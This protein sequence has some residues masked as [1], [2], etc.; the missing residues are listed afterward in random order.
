MFLVTRKVG[1]KAAE[2]SAAQVHEN[3]QG[4]LSFSPHRHVRSTVRRAAQ[5][6]MQAVQQHHYDTEARLR[7]SLPYATS[8]PNKQISYLCIYLF[9][10]Q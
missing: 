7:F 8:Q 10:R 4:R 5:A 6:T 3:H 9:T 2:E 1:A